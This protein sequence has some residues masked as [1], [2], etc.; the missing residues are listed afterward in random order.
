MDS[1]YEVVVSNK[2]SELTTL[3]YSSTEILE[4]ALVKVKTESDATAQ[5]RLIRDLLIPKMADLRHYADEAETLTDENV[6]PFPTYD[7]LMF[8]VR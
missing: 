7:K 5:S 2:L 1:T 3:T 8:A 4:K 6:W